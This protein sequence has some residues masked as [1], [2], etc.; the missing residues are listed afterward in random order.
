MSARTRFL[1]PVVFALVLGAVKAC[2]D[3]EEGTA[4][5]ATDAGTD[6]V[7]PDGNTSLGPSPWGERT[8]VTETVALDGLQGEVSAVRDQYGMVHIYARTP[9]DAVRVQ[10]YMMAVDRGGQLELARRLATGR[11]AE[12]LAA[13]DPGQINA[14]ITMRTIG[15]HRAAK[16]M[17]DGLD[18]TSE[19]KS[20]LDAFADG[21]TS[22]NRAF[23][24]GK[25]ELAAPLV[26]MN[27]K[28]FSDWTPADTLAM[29]RLQSFS[30][31][32]DANADIGL[33]ARVDDLRAFFDPGS[34]DP[35]I[36]KRSG[37][38]K[39]MLRFAPPVPNT[40]LL[41]FPDEPTPGAYWLKPELRRGATRPTT[42]VPQ[43]AVAFSKSLRAQ[44]QPF[45]DAVTRV[46]DFVGG[47]EFAGSNNWAVAGSKSAT[48][49]ALMANDPHLGLSAPMVFWPTHLVVDNPDSPERDLEAIGLAF[50]GIPGVILG[51]NRHVAW[52]A[53]TAGY[54]VTDVWREKLS[55]DGQ[56]VMFKG[57]KVAFQKVTETLQIAGAPDYSWDVLVVP[58]HGPVVPAI[59]DRKVVPP[60]PGSEALSVRWT[61]H[62]PS[63]DVN[64]VIGLLRAKNVDEA[65][66]ALAAFGVGAQNWML[67]DSAGDIAWTA[68]A[69]IPRRDK[70]AFTWDPATFTG[71]LP[72][73]ILDGES[74]DHEWTGMLEEQYQPKLVRPSKG[75]IATANTDNVASTVDND[76][77]NDT[78]PGGEPFYIG[79]EFA[80][81]Y[82]LAR[83]EERLIAEVDGMT[84]TGMADLQA[85]HKSPL[86]TRFAPEFV[87]ALQRAEAERLTPGTHPDL[88]A[89]VADPRYDAAEVTAVL[90]DL[91]TWG[92]QGYLA[93]A[94]INL[95]DDS[96]N[97]PTEEADNARATLIFNAWLVRA[98]ARTFEDELTLVD[99][100]N[101][102]TN[103]TLRA[104]SLL[105]LED[106][107]TLATYD[108]VTG[109]SALWDDIS[110]VGITESRDDRLVTAL[111]DALA[112]LKS[113]VG[114]DQDAWRWGDQHRV[115]FNGLNPLWLVSIPPVTD[116][117]FPKGFP[118]HGDQW[119]VDASNF[120]ITRGLTDNF[121]FSYGSGPVQRVVAE[122]TPTGPKIRNALPGG[123]VLAKES[124]YF[125]D[126]AELWR[127]N[128][129]HPIPFEVEE[130]EASANAAPLVQHFRFVPGG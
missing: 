48:G 5:P 114:A 95:D 112:D 40:P 25:V 86:G 31:S 44:V 88:A 82:R 33:T 60:A 83:I 39:D 85:D 68:P 116:P 20:L 57:Q 56:G 128:Q 49:N 119:N 94:G 23:R 71:T 98:I 122:M 84:P 52:G 105:L 16:A 13:A 35:L 102:G 67:A 30:L 109:Q 77:S 61:G 65:R 130:V 103:F 89:V 21:V 108:P 75:W 113:L 37:I 125:R 74:G 28:D 32:Y 53:T 27:A 97:V 47:D 93:A 118:R 43:T 96:L 50:P 3:G 121:S 81:G 107:T 101:V 63:D 106:P 12:I 115:R 91:D 42:D 38:L 17:Y 15:L 124:P 123:A 1:P 126:E 46:Q 79:C 36:Q 111:L 4:R 14:D 90:A 10:G 9:E 34:T 69:L 62:A 54:D 26:G 55:S 22:F 6:V 78:L 73:L 64:A 76:P 117:V 87:L 129:S 51:A 18:P 92:N 120:S 11:V 8:P 2:G 72:C 80:Q 24:E 127:K 66:Q 99:R 110:T 41:G 59:V 104:F 45:L 19:V 100:K 7:V 58:H 70:Q 29:G